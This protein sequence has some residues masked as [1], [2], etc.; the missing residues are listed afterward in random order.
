M[1]PPEDT[2]TYTGRV[3]QRARFT[4]GRDGKGGAHAHD[5]IHLGLKRG[6]HGEVVHGRGNHHHIGGIKLGNQHVRTVQ[7]AAK[8][9]A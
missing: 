8:V 9:A 2:A 5:V 3:A 1:K 4:L 6:G 7:C